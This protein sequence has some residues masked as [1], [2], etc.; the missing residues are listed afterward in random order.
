MATSANII[1]PNTSDTGIRNATG[2]CYFHLDRS[3]GNA[4]WKTK[5]V[6]G[7]GAFIDANTITLRSAATSPSTFLTL[8]SGTVT[9]G[10]G[11]DLVTA[12][13]TTTNPNMTLTS[14]ATGPT[15]PASGDLWNLSGVLK[16]H[17]GTTTRDIAFTESYV[18][19]T[20]TA[21][22][23][24]TLTATTSNLFYCQENKA[25]HAQGRWAFTSAGTASNALLIDTTTL[26]LPAVAGVVGFFHYFDSGN[27]FFFGAVSM[28]ATGQLS[29]FSHGGNNNFGQGPA[30]TV[31]SGDSIDINLSYR[32]V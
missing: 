15:S 31:A 20:G 3:S 8:T 10:A 6:V 2:S 9:L 26:P 28:S 16:F 1:F 12:A 18:A 23:N 27:Q 11:I 7:A 30:I 21:K 19:Y 4:Q 32:S 14:S 13:P 17:N 29:F 22:Q 25:V 5:D 24:V